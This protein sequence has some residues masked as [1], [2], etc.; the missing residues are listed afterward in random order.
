MPTISDDNPQTFAS[1][2][3]ITDAAIYYGWYAGEIN[4][5][6]ANEGF[7]FKPGA[8]A[9][10]LHSYSAN[11]LRSETQNWCGPLIARRAAATLGNVY[12]PYLA[13]TANFSIFQDRLMTG[14]TL[15][16]SAWMSQ[17]VVSW[18]GVVIGDPL[19]R[20]Y[21]AWNAFT[22]PATVPPITGERFERH[23][24]F[25]IECAECYFFH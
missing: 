16:E 18:A 3:P 12:E 1:G 25:Q 10:H 22:I 9:V 23:T 2:F 24:Q 11:T 8:V 14:L 19:Y 21:S 20:P 17:R 6:F 13:F 5:P 4:G 15:A 7:Q